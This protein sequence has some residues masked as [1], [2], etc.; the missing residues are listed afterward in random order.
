MKGKIQRVVLEFDNCIKELE[1]S[2]AEDWMERL[3]ANC[4]FAQSHD[5]NA[6]DG[7]AFSQFKVTSKV[8][9]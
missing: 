6:M 1:G 4:S 9:K 3:N 7:F 2:A 8:E 5:C